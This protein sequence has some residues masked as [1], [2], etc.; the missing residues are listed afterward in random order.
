M[1]AMFSWPGGKGNFLAKRRNYIPDSKKYAEPFAGAATY[2]FYKQPSPIEILNDIDMRIVN[3]FRVMQDKELFEELKYRIN[4]TPYAV[5]EFAK[6][7]KVLELGL[8]NPVAYA[9]AFFV[10]KNQGFS[11]SSKSRARWSRTKN[12][13]SDG[14]SNN[15]NSWLMRLQMFDAW[16]WRL[17]RCQIDCRDAIEFI[18]YWDAPDMVFYVDPPYVLD[19]RTG[20]GKKL[21]VNEPDDEYHKK[22]IQTLLNVQGSVT[23]SGYPHIIY[24]SLVENG[25][26]EYKFQTHVN[27]S[28]SNGTRGT[29]KKKSKRT[30]VIWINPKEQG[31]EL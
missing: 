14:L 7:I 18:K 16:R 20:G 19:T 30:E 13:M 22:L 25:W 6:A 17:M 9:W 10:T 31:R 1:K 3:I 26:F 24:K 2:F 8:E 15:V 12:S 5:E 27:I 4:Y 28:L 23:L 21:Y 11:G 29:S